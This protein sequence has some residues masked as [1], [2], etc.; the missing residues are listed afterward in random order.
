MRVKMSNW[1]ANP[2]SDAQV[3]HA[4]ADAAAGLY[5]A[6]SLFAR[7][8]GPGGGPRAP[9]P[10]EVDTAALAAWL[11]RAAAPARAAS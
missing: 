5:V 7:F 8:G 1:G 6:A 9:S 11:A 2:L 4:A 3:E 10:E